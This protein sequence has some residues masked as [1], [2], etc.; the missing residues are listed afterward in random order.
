MGTFDISR[1]NFDPKKHYQSVRMQQGRVLTDDDWNENERIGNEE[2]R[3]SLNDTIGSYGTSN[4]GFKIDQVR[5]N[6]AGGIDFNILAGTIYLG[7]Q[8]FE[9]E[10]KEPF[11]AQKDWLQQ[12]V[13]SDKIPKVAV[14]SEQYDLVYLE[15]WQQPV[16]AVEDSSLFEEALG[17]PD[18]TTRVRKMRRVKV[19]SDVGSADCS[20]AWKKLTGDWEKN[21]LG[22]INR[23]YERI[24]D[25]KLSVTFIGDG[26]SD[27]LC[28]PAAAGGYLGAENQAI[29]VQI[30]NDNSGGK[31]ITWGFDNASP[32]YRVKV[33]FTNLTVTMLTEPKD[34]YH[35]PLSGQVVEILP[36]SAVLSNNEKI[37]EISGNLYKVSS[38]YDPDSG[39]LTLLDQLPLLMKLDEVDR[40]HLSDINYLSDQTLPDYYFMRVWNRG[41]DLIS[42]ASIDVPIGSEIP[43]GNTGLAITFSGNDWVPGDFWVIAARP[44]TPNQVVPWEL[45]TGI[46]HHGIRRFYAPLAVIRWSNEGQHTITGEVVH[47]CRKRFRPLTDINRCCTYEVGD[48]VHS[49]GDFHSIEE[50]VKQLPAQGG[51]ICVL[52]GVHH[53]NLSVVDRENIHITGCGD[54]TIVHPRVKTPGQ[55]IFGF[56]SCRNIR[57][58]NLTLITHT[59]IAVL[60]ED[61]SDAANATEGLTI[62]RNRIFAL[63][64]AIRIGVKNELAGKNAI[65]ICDNVIGMWDLEGGD[66][67]IFT[68]ADDVLIH[69][70]EISVVSAPDPQDPQDS[71]DPKGPDGTLFT[72]CIDKVQFYDQPQWWMNV[73]YGTLAYMNV[74]WAFKPIEYKAKGGIQIGGGSEM[75]RI[76]YNHITGG[77]GNGVTLGDLPTEGG[78]GNDFKNKLFVHQLDSM[79][80]K[81]L[82][83]N[84]LGNLYEIA[85]ENNF[86]AGVGL[87]GIGVAAF[88]H[89]EEVGLMISVDEITIR[90]NHITKCANQVPDEK[91]ES[92]LNEVGFGGIV[93][94]SCENVVI[95]NNKIQ[96]NGRHENKAVCGVLILYG[97]DVDISNNRIINNG[98]LGITGGQALERGLRGG[99]V[100]LLSFKQ[101]IYEFRQNKGFTRPDG[102]PAVKVHDNIVVQPIGQAL[103]LIVFGPVSVVGN[104]FT[105]Q[106][107]DYKINPLSVIAGA[108]LIINL[109]LSQDLMAALLLK[110][111]RYVATGNQKQ[112][113][114]VGG[115][116]GV[117]NTDAEAALRFLYLPGGSV[118]YNANQ[119]TLDLQ[120]KVIDLVLSAQ[121]IVSLDDVAYN[122]NQSE[123]RS[124]FDIILSNAVLVGATVRASDNRFQEGFT[125]TLNSLISVGFMNMAN[126]NQAT[127]CIQVFGPKAFTVEIANSI[128]YQL[129]PCARKA[130]VIG[131]FF[132]VKLQTAG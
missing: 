44:E 109:G 24:P 20:E 114:E 132:G 81:Y 18:T 19:A 111:F 63:T 21:N 98:P 3:R 16:S 70:N 14:G 22:L 75:V 1:I 88:L 77:S 50:A 66:A 84:L 94:A 117:E 86:I 6:G 49:S 59:G 124:L 2:L 131:G 125:I 53:A 34:Q 90:E 26:V 69:N 30:V 95:S 65:R 5:D 92:M 91:P 103:L 28:T 38:S 130:V 107:A 122:S 89:Q 32:L 17:G 72:P 57:I 35:W 102:I 119:T 126:A 97:E 25:T 42:A 82:E 40:F 39:Q 96:D 104:Q 64:H 108:V 78:T 29:R 105:T 79:H 115:M 73:V 68:C 45:E 8:R 80:Q 71:R 120:D 10:Q 47:D 43:L 56:S 55:E 112:F 118:M 51:R 113:T 52:P 41:T 129:G 62:E 85:I 7:G 36:W 123:V 37:A 127:H 76:T 58:D 101:L 13:D 9:L 93:L 83:Q 23:E 67:A 100:V 87:S 15:A 99:I 61:A 46:I 110:S 27:D 31:K 60:V 11:R 74:A 121:A 12:P 4:N 33:D 54:Q 48:G 128:L 106:C 116:T